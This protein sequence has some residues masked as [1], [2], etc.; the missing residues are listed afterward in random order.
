MML[1]LRYIDKTRFQ[2]MRTLLIKYNHA[3]IYYYL[4]FIIMIIIIIT[5]RLASLYI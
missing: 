2:R 3:P 4:A 5:N 1:K